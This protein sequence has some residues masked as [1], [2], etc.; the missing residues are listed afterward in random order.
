[1]GSPPCPPR[2]V[3]GFLSRVQPSV[4][5]LC[6]LAWEPTP[7]EVANQRIEDFVAAGV[8]HMHQY[9]DDITMYGTTKANLR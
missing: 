7:R 4:V 6:A 5:V 8:Y 9:L 1:M 3:V 2:V